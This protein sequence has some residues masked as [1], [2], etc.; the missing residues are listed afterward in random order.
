MHIPAHDQHDADIDYFA[1]DSEGHVLHVASGGGRLPGSVAASEEVLLELHAYFLSRAETTS[2]EPGE[3]VA[4]HHTEYPSHA[5]Y[6]RRGLFSFG[7]TD[8]HNG[9]H[10]QY[11]LVARPA[12]PLTVAELPKAIGQLLSRTRLPAPAATSPTFDVGTML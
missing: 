1:A 7:K 11:R 6:A 12:Q 10:G 8:L 9:A 5:R 2:A 4:V 3:G